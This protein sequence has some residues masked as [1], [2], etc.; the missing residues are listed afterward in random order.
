MNE[1]RTQSKNMI[2][3]CQIK[4]IIAYLSKLLA[5]GQFEN[6]AKIFKIFIGFS[7]KNRENQKNRKS[8]IE[9]SKNRKSKIQKIFDENIDFSIFRKISIFR[10]FIEN[11]MEN[12]KI[13]KATSNWP[14]AK[15]FER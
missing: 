6:P 9:K 5:G 13:F 2:D 11:P 3:L 15:S 1:T 14:P 8:K 12:L 10:F 7:M 4:K